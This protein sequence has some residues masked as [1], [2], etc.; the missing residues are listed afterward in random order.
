M[1]PEAGFGGNGVEV[2][3]FHC[4]KAIADPEHPAGSF[5][6]P[7]FE[8]VAPPA[9]GTWAPCSDGYGGGHV[10]CHVCG[11]WFSSDQ[12]WAKGRPV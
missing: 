5:A 9:D 10:L 1:S 6:W 3:C 12:G 2:P 8:L 11:R 4:F 7:T